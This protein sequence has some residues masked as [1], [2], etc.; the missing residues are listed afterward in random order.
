MIVVV[1]ENRERRYVSETK[2]RNTRK[3]LTELQPGWCLVPGGCAIYLSQVYND[4]AVPVQGHAMTDDW[5]A[6][7]TLH[8]HAQN[9]LKAS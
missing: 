2:S 9:Y 1:M 8:V 6:T 5:H 7:S 3:S 4:A